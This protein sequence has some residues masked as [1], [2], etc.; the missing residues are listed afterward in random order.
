MKYRFYWVG[1]LVCIFSVLVLGIRA[2]NAQQNDQQPGRYKTVEI[3]TTQY[4]WQVVSNRTGAILCELIIEEDRK[5]T[6]DETIITCASAIYFSVPTATPAPVRKG[7]TTPAPTPLPPYDRDTFLRS[8]SY[9]LDEVR[10]F[11]R[12]VNV[13]MQE[14]IVNLKVPPERM[15]DPYIIVNAYEPEPEYAITEIQGKVNGT[16]FRCAQSP[17]KVPITTDS[18][19]EFWAISSFGDESVHVNALFRVTLQNN[20][21]SLALQSLS[22]IITYRDSCADIWDVP[23]DAKP[24]WALFPNSPEDLATN[25]RLFYLAEQLIKSGVV[26]AKDCPGG[27]LFSDGSPNACGMLRAE[28]E[29]IRWQNQ[30]DV[31]IWATG[32]DLGLPPK[33]I[34]SILEKES[35]FWPSNT[36]YYLYEFGIAQ[37]N[38]LGAD[39]ALRWDN[40]LFQQVCNGLLYD[41]S[42]AY[43]SLPPWLQASMRGGLVRSINADCGECQYGIDFAKAVHSVPTVGRLLRAN[44][45]QVDHIMEENNAVARYEDLWRFTMVSYHSGYDCIRRAI[46]DTKKDSKAVNWTNVALN[47]DNTCLGATDYVD[48]FWNQLE[49]F[50][51]NRLQPVTAEIPG[52]AAFMPTAVPSPT[53]APPVTS[54]T[55]RVM[56]YVDANRNNRFDPGEGVNDVEVR[57]EVDDGT[58]YSKVL[59]DGV[60]LFPMTGKKIGARAVVSIPLLFRSEQVLLPDTGDVPVS[61]RLEEPVAPPAL[62]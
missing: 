41:C 52:Q 9:R 50:D 55:I 22:P 23:N 46:F 53:P 5:P 36:V 18:V 1:A 37:I 21:Y 3:T 12:I 61:F 24:A 26:D 28:P 49:T 14:I 56:V 17:C 19:V 51:A 16:G 38:E 57:V 39:V 44:C 4:V 40:E 13:P 27:G 20:T 8:I 42:R 58:S 15:A 2:S 29:M 62:P 59:T 45:Y 43:A 35:Q 11:T 54:S 6:D 10:E 25:K 48:D 60:A 47:L 34:K 33:V 31:S 32:R 30:Y 7:D